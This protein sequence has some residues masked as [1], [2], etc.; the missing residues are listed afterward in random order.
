M[1]VLFIAHEYPPYTFGG[2]A[3]YTYILANKLA[4]RG[5]NVTVVSGISDSIRVEMYRKNLTVIRIPFPNMF[6]HEVWFQHYNRSLLLS[7]A[8]RHDIIHV[9]QCAASS[10]I[11][12]LISLQKPVVTTIHYNHVDAVKAFASMPA[13]DI[14]KYSTLEDLVLHGPR[15]MLYSELEAL[16]YEYSTVLIFVARHVLENFKKYYGTMRGKAFVIYNGVNLPSSKPSKV[17]DSYDFYFAGRH[18]LYKGVIYVIKAFKEICN[19][20]V[21]T[22]LFIF[23]KGPLTKVISKEI[24]KMPF[25]VR[26]KIFLRGYIP[27]NELIKR[28]SSSNA[29][30]FP[31]VYEACPVSL[32]EAYSLGIPAVLWDLPWTREFVV[33]NVTTLLVKPFN[34]KTNFRYYKNLYHYR[35]LW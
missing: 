29:F 8:T 11:K 31:S 2:I 16:D 23:G 12:E 25:P 26:K 32:I 13:I 15:A 17:L 27:Y 19:E 14:L 22:H 21:N 6:P 3:R 7:L 10:F 35:C 33:P 30:I 28:I 24:A 5:V 4:L 18:Y 20:M 1:K 34:I 9:N